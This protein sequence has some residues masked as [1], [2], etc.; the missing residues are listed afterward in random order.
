MIIWGQNARYGLTRFL[1]VID[2]ATAHGPAQARS[3]NNDFYRD[4]T[5][6]D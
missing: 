3:R 5:L 2:F 4:R 6:S 1:G